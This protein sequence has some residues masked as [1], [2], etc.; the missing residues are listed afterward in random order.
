MQAKEAI[1]IYNNTPYIYQG[2]GWD[3]KMWSSFLIHFYYLL[4]P[5][6]LEQINSTK[7]EVMKH[8]A[9]IMKNIRK[10]IFVL[11]RVYRHTT[12]SGLSENIKYQQSIWSKCLISHQLSNSRGTLMVKTGFLSLGHAFC[13]TGHIRIAGCSRNPHGWCRAWSCTSFMKI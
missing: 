13:R 12:K 8:P 2:T 11:M 10:F 1:I 7:Q 3:N 5:T 6:R 9:G 4:T